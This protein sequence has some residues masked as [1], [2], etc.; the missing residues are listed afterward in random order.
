MHRVEFRS[1][2]KVVSKSPTAP[3]QTVGGGCFCLLRKRPRRIRSKR[4]IFAVRGSSAG[5]SGVGAGSVGG[6]SV[7][8]ASSS[9]RPVVSAAIIAL[10]IDEGGGHW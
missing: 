7:A 8:L 6:G 1:R 3:S 4:A 5:V 2:G 9:F 10:L